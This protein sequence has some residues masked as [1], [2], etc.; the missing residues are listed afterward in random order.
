[1][2]T[3]EIRD[4]EPADAGA[5]DAVIA[6]AFGRRAEADLVAALREAGD[7]ALSLV[8]VEDGDIVG[9]AGF[10]RVKLSFPFL[11]ATALAPLSVR[12]DRQ[13]SGIGAALAEAGLTRLAKTGEAVCLVLG[14]PDYYRRFGFTARE[15]KMLQ[16]PWDGPQMQA[17]WFRSV[18]LGPFKASYPPAFTAL[19]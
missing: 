18:P 2:A 7:L 3:I 8:A 19:G 5:I 1:M 11:H 6:A 4:A 14:E 9:H 17:R 12:P 16:T 13:R 15:A 10:A